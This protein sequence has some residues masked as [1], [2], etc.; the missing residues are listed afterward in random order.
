MK[1]LKNKIAWLALGMFTL[2]CSVDLYAQKPVVAIFAWDEKT[3]E[4]GDPGE[5]QILQ[6]G[7]P[8]HNLTVRI[9]IEGTASDGLDYRCFDDTWKVDKMKN[10]KILPI[11]DGIAEG[12]E[13]VIVSLL[14]SPDYEIEEMHQTAIVTI[15]DA[16]LPVA[17]FETPSSI[18]EEGE[19]NVI[20]KVTL[21]KAYDKNVELDYSVQ[22]VIA[23][24]GTDFQLNNGTLV[25]PAGKKEAAIQLKVYNDEK[26][27]GDETV[28]IRLNKV[29][30]ANIGTNHAH[31]YTILNDDGAFA[32]SVVY[33]RIMGVLLGFRAGCS[34]GAVT[35]YNWN[36]QRIESTF[37]LLEEFKPFVHYNDSWTHPAGATEDGGER[38]KLI[39]TAIMEKKDRIN[40]KDLEEVWLRDCDIENMDHMTQNYDRVL[41]S[42]AKWGVPPEDFPITKY[43][44]PEDLGEHIHLT[45]R[46]FQALPCINAGDPENAIADMN[47]MG[48]LYYE[49]PDDDAFAW[50][51]VYNAA[52]ALALL[53][54]ATVESVIEGALKYATPEIKKELE[55][56]MSLTEKYDDPMNRGMWQELTDVYVNPKSRYYAFSRIEKYPNSSIY[57]N[58]GLAFA[59][60]KAT[61]ANVKQ[62]VVIAVNRGYDTDC[63]AA[64]AG[65]LCGALSGTSTIPGN[66]IKIVDDG[67]ANNPYSNAH[68]TNK[69]T[70]DGL[71]LA[72]QNKVLRLEKEID[73][74]KYGADETKKIKAYIQLMRGAGVVDNRP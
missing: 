4:S 40:Y 24:N 74:K 8:V 17:E 27:E 25:I 18:G 57:E 34:M 21:S 12:D 41:L 39:C 70:A 10:F 58:V 37:G 38:H 54:N 31:Y 47:N 46:T 61:R 49:D 19:E 32:K 33:D 44:K 35:E 48:K 56:V 13:T 51:A 9:K 69:A 11:D 59:L 15:Q 20:I 28:V 3:R 42:Y 1:R 43:G 2:L 55:Y 64:S 68:F 52:I 60:F 66:W 50:G 71:F 53:P 67:T 65:A 45:A 36:Q 6:L 63:T 73:A 5:I 7:E 14:E 72:L 23:E 62:S 29:R 16:S 30:N 22:G 26:A